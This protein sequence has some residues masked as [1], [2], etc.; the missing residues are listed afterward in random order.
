MAE[1]VAPL[2]NY[3]LIFATLMILTGVTVTVAFV[4]LGFMNTVVALSIAGFKATLVVLY[5]MHLRYSSS[6]P[7]LFWV[8]GLLW[9]A[10]LLG[11]TM[12]DYLTR[13]WMDQPEGWTQISHFGGTKS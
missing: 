13:Q 5:F 4:D 9:L 1:H 3:L 7:K 8:A 2:R 12:S 6:L 10:I 11:F